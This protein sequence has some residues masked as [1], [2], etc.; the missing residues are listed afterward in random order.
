MTTARFDVEP[1]PPRDQLQTRLEKALEQSQRMKLEAHSDVLNVQSTAEEHIELGNQKVRVAEERAEQL[2]TELL[3]TRQEAEATLAA[4][5]R[6]L[7]AQHT[8]C[9]SDENVHHRY[10]NQCSARGDC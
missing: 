3:H 4:H 8:K 9:T 6:M 2:E 5:N 10:V 7:A 1:R